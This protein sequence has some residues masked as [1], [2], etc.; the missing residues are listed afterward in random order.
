MI[1]NVISCCN[2]GKN[3]KTKV[4]AFSVIGIAILATSYFI[5]TTTNSSRAALAFSG[6]LGFAACP[7]MCAV[8][9]GGMWIASRFV[10]KK[11]QKDNSDQDQEQSC[12]AKHTST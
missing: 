9:G 2:T 11:S 1:R 4:I 6:I 5:F 12:C 3:T 7:A 10:N 8:M